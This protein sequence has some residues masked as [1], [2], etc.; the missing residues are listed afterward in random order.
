MS[1][2]VPNCPTRP[3]VDPSEPSYL[4]VKESS[5]RDQMVRDLEL[6]LSLELTNPTSVS[7]RLA[8]KSRYGGKVATGGFVASE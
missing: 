3:S 8:R 4:V 5:R 1:L 2:H 7:L 6:F